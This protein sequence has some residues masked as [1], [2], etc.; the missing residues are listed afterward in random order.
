MTRT[1]FIEALRQENKLVR[2]ATDYPVADHMTING[3]TIYY[4]LI[5][6]IDLRE[7]CCDIYVRNSE[8][9]ERLMLMIFYSDIVTVGS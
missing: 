2:R 8:N 7:L 3:F 6:S 9:H 1:Q 5:S 4:D